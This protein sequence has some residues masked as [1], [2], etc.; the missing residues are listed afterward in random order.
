M[1]QVPTLKGS[2]DTGALPDDNRRQGLDFGHG[3]LRC[4][5]DLAKMIIDNPRRHFEAVASRF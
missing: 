1:A 4:G 2:I 3:P 5:S